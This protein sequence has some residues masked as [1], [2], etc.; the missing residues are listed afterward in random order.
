MVSGKQLLAAATTFAIVGLVVYGVT[1][2][3]NEIDALAFSGTPLQVIRDAQS[4]AAIALYANERDSPTSGYALVQV[5]Q[6]NQSSLQWLSSARVYLVQS[7]ANGR[8][9]QV[10]TG[11]SGLNKLGL[12]LYYRVNG[13]VNVTD[14]EPIPAAYKVTNAN[15]TFSVDNST[16]SVSGSHFEYYPQWA[17]VNSS[18]SLAKGQ[19]YQLLLVATRL[20]PETDYD[21]VIG[22]GKRN[23]TEMAWWNVSWESKRQ[24][25]SSNVTG[26][27]SNTFVS[28]LNLS[29][30]TLIAQKLMLVNCSDLRVSNG[31]ETVDYSYDIDNASCNTNSTFVWA[32]YPT[33]GNPSVNTTS[34]F[35]FNNSAAANKINNPTPW[36]DS[37]LMS[38]A[39]LADKK[40]IPP[41]ESAP[42][43]VKWQTLGGTLDN[44]PDPVL[45]ASGKFGG[46]ARIMSNGTA[47]YAYAVYP[48][49]AWIP[50]NLP[51]LTLNF[52]FYSNGDTGT[53]NETINKLA[54]NQG[55]VIFEFAS[56]ATNVYHFT[57]AVRDAT[58][59][60]ASG[61]WEGGTFYIPPN[62][63]HMITMRYNGTT[64]AAVQTF[65]D[66]RINTTTAATLTLG[67]ANCSAHASRAALPLSIGAH[68]SV[69]NGTTLFNT[70]KMDAYL[71][72]F[73][74]WNRSLSNDEI[75]D[76][77]NQTYGLAGASEAQPPLLW[78]DAAVNST[79][80]GK[81]ALFSLRW[82]STKGLANATFSF[83]QGDGVFRNI[84]NASL[85]GFS[86]WTNQTI[87]LNASNYSVIRWRVWANDT[88]NNINDSG[89][90]TLLSYNRPK[91]FNTSLNNQTMVNT[92]EI[93][94]AALFYVNLTAD[95]GLLNATLS[96]D[97]GVGSFSNV[98]IVRITGASNFTNFTYK[99]AAADGDLVKWRVFF[100]DTLG[101]ANVTDTFSFY[102]R[103]LSFLAVRNA[104]IKR[105]N[106]SQCTFGSFVEPINQS[107][108]TPFYMVSSV[109][110]NPL[111]IQLAVNQTSPNYTICASPAH[112]SALCK[113]L[114][115]ALTD[116][117]AGRHNLTSLS[118]NGS[119]WLFL[120][121]SFSNSTFTSLE[122]YVKVR[123]VGQ[124]EGVGGG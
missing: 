51:Y 120:N 84:S 6:V 76:L 8:S 39:H 95:L 31:T 74:A 24:V 4:G 105:L 54:T 7:S 77:F 2:A 5:G 38:V 79:A 83:D 47:T 111:R 66:G 13:T 34:Y 1:G 22:V 42:N 114:T 50:A 26:G 52:W 116:V 17:P 64:G 119:I 92:T 78:Y 11:L 124:A 9:A 21:W 27:Y 25:N 117:L 99:L 115:T 69:Y 36:T 58:D 107:N 82:A 81:A 113:P 103:N 12:Q 88:F 118:Q 87:V 96:I 10:V 16:A 121:C 29:T 71:D 108:E 80:P 49:T 18:F 86:N 3:S 46:A 123:F 93:S 61:N 109:S 97:N 106:V 33:G 48:H 23:F 40:C 60:C 90:F 37:G 55:H 72:E 45:P 44:C 56:T 75:G 28:V 41:L 30:E 67:L 59:A 110:T 62:Q 89:I 70:E 32:N 19:T 100:N 68:T 73:R 63:W 65:Y 94:E 102:A 85:L 15:G 101:N 122:P 20:N 14:Y 53:G 104:S 112:D 35:Y 43:G 98:S 57:G 91:S